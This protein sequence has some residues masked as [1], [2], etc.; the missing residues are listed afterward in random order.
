MWQASPST[1]PSP[2][3]N[4]EAVAWPV[5]AAAP[6]P[7]WAVGKRADSGLPVILRSD[8]AGTS[9]IDQ[10]LPAGAPLSGNGLESVWF[11]DGLHGW[12]VGAHGLVLHT[13]TGGR[14]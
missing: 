12:A 6:G 10:A 2:F 5:P 13:V 4:L 11:V 9:W 8:D 7:A 1:L 3:T 14:P